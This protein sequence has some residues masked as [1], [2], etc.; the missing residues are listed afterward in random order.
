MPPRT[1]K[2]THA[3]R[4]T[5]ATHIKVALGGVI[6]SQYE[7]E[8]ILTGTPSGSASKSEGASGS[9]DASGSKKVSSS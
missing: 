4:T 5:R 8:R 3:A 9:A 6:A 1:L 7:E 2:P